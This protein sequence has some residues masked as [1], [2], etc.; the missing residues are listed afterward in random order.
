MIYMEEV[1]KEG[2]INIT[3]NEEDTPEETIVKK[4]DDKVKGEVTGLVNESKKVYDRFTKYNLNRTT[5]NDELNMNIKYEK[6]FRDHLQKKLNKLDNRLNIL[7]MKY[8]RYKQWYD[9]FNIMI[10]IISSILSIYEAFRNE[11]FDTIDDTRND[12]KV[13]LNM[14]PIGI[15]STIT[16]SAAIIKFKKYQEKMENM[17]FTRE[18]VLMAIS[19]LKMA[20]ESLWFSKDNT[21]FQNIKKKYL[22]D[23]YVMYNESNSELER[24]IKFNDYH[25]FFKLYKEPPK[26]KDKLIL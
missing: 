20:Q 6:D 23:V 26:Q 5:N 7:Q 24:H 2:D 22:E 14:I 12:L 18:K 21:D 13:T 16:C 17:Q 8:N 9:R 15:S 11:I 4:L 10:I 19:K 1:S 3:I 25:K